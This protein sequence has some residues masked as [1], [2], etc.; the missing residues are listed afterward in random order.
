MVSE[1]VLQ[2]AQSVAAAEA[3]GDP[4]AAVSPADTASPGDGSASN[5]PRENDEPEIMP[6]R[7]SDKIKKG[8][9]VLEI[10]AGKSDTIFVDGKAMGSGPVVSVALKAKD[11]PYEIKVRLRDEDRV[12][13]VAVKEGKLTRVRV[14]A[15]WSR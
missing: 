1:D 5:K 8:Q 15:P 2:P 7:E 10:V 13:R 4:A 14:A 9:G 6:L 12:R 3:S 11:D